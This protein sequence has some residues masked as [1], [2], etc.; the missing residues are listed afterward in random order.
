MPTDT[1]WARFERLRAGLDI[2]NDAEFDRRYGIPANTQKNWRGRGTQPSLE[3]LEELAEM[4]GVTIDYLWS[5]TVK[6]DADQAAAQA[7]AQ[8][9]AEGP[10][11]LPRPR[12][13]RGTRGARGNT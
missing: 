8:T 5:G 6:T 2:H 13:R 1:F 9:I 10:S 4:F 11:S 7:L 12:R 3:A